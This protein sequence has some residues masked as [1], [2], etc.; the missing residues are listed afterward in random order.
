MVMPKKP[1]Q[2]LS[3]PSAEEEGEVGAHASFKSFWTLI[4]ESPTAQILLIYKIKFN[5]NIMEYHGI[6]T[7][8]IVSIK[9]CSLSV[10]AVTSAGYELALGDSQTCNIWAIHRHV[11]SG[12]Q[13]FFSMNFSREF[14]SKNVSHF[15]IL[16][17]TS[18][19]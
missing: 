11:I 7:W 2:K 6:G 19:L 10:W 13:I 14:C 3:N 4:T 16:S 9:S 1:E 17:C 8:K 15:L 12:Y 18:W 5:T